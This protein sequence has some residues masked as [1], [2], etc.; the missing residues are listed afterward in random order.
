MKDSEQVYQTQVYIRS[1]NCI[2]SIDLTETEI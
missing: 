2:R 1:I